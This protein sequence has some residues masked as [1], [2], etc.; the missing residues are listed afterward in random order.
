MRAI[1]IISVECSSFMEKQENGDMYINIS[2]ISGRK[3]HVLDNV[4]QPHKFSSSHSLSL[5]IRQTFE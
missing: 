4:H 3:Q 1:L 2:E 5:F